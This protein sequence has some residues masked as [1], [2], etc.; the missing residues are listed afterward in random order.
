MGILFV[1]DE[2]GMFEGFCEFFKIE[3][4]VNMSSRVF[5]CGY[6][7]NK[8]DWYEKDYFLFFK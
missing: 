1:F 2:D 3:D 8:I 5:S 4:V 7:D 6:I